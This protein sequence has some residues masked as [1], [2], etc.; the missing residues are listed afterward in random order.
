MFLNPGEAPELVKEEHTYN[1][2]YCEA[3][4]V[5]HLFRCRIE[6]GFSDS[7]NAACPK[8]A[9]DLGEIRC[10]LGSPEYLGSRKGNHSSSSQGIIPTGFK[11]MR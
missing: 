5:T 7:A 3:C 6:R 1:A 9:A 10:D 2:V 4:K 11:R 8:C